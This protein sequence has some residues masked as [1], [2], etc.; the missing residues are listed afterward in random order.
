MA[1]RAPIS[2]IPKRR[3]GI[4]IIGATD[5]FVTMGKKRVTE[6]TDHGAARVTVSFAE[7][8]ATQAI[9]GLMIE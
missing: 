4:A 6:F 9:T 5:Q 2:S 3:S 1:P 8:E 7:G